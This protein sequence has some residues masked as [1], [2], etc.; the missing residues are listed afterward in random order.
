MAVVGWILLSIL[1]LLLALILAIL[2]VPIRYKVTAKLNAQEKGVSVKVTWLLSL[3]RFFFDFPEPK[4]PILKVAFVTILGK[5]SK[6]G[7]P[8]KSKKKKAKN[9]GEESQDNTS[10]EATQEDHIEEAVQEGLAEEDAKVESIEEDVQEKPSEEDDREISSEEGAQEGHSEEAIQEEQSQV[11]SSDAEKEPTSESTDIASEDS[12]EDKSKKEKKAKPKVP[13][14]EK[15]QKIKEEV[16]FY[17]ELWEDGNAK[18]FVQSALARVFHVVKNLL[19][20]KVSGKLLFGAA[21]P[22]V[23]GYVYGVYCMLRS[24]W[25]KR[26]P[27]EFSPDFESQVLEGELMI[28]GRFCI[29]TILVDALRIWFDKRLKILRS[30]L[31]AKKGKTKETDQKH[32]KKRKKNKKK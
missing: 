24:T 8:K 18:P 2:F 9:E 11:Q 29:F 26:F 13:F 12:K 22:D 3:V 1:L 25:P 19:P 15:L 20:R 14:R 7:K 6:P 10:E 31:D 27:L 23:T 17:K 28:K 4:E 32:K 30:K 5:K 16:I 21:T